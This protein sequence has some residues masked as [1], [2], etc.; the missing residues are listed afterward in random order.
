VE[1]AD[2]LGLNR[3]QQYIYVILPQSFRIAIPPTLGF[4]VQIVGVGEQWN[5]E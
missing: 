4:M 2:C 5:R 1:A 3:F